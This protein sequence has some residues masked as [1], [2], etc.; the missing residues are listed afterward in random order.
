MLEDKIGFRGVFVFGALQMLVALAFAFAFLRKIS[1]DRP[2]PQ[3]ASL[4]DGASAANVRLL[5]LLADREFLGTL[6]LSAIPAAL[7]LAGFLYFASPLFLTEAGVSQSNIARLMMPYGLCMIYLAP[8][9]GKWVDAVGDKRIPVLLG[10]VLGGT[11]LLIFHF[12]H[13]PLAFV[14]ILILFSVSGGLSYGA[15]LTL[16]SESS[17]A[18][19]VGVSRALGVFSSLERVGNILGPMLVGSLLVVFSVTAAIGF[20]GLVFLLCNLLLFFLCLSRRHSLRA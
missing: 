20:I 13:S 5:S 16:V 6:L 18:R 10:G 19:G 3:S 7:C 2:V 8:L 1:S 14:A 15:R 11:A 12:F 4:S 17:G 9:L